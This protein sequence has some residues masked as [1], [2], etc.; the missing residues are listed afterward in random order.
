MLSKLGGRDKTGGRLSN[1][2]KCVTKNR[3]KALQKMECKDREDHRRNSTWLQH[4]RGN[5]VSTD[6]PETRTKARWC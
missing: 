1:T 6:E 2:K 5:R 3:R 4:K